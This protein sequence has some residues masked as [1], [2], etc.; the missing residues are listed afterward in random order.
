M[1][2]AY[3]ATTTRTQVVTS[4]TVFANP[5][6]RRH[7]AHECNAN[8]LAGI[9][10]GVRS[11]LDAVAFVCSSQVDSA[12]HAVACAVASS[13]ALTVSSTLILSVMLF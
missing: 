10:D 5:M 2:S 4:L 11:A 7:R 3:V 13:L 12:S 1:T 9:V 8:N 6:H